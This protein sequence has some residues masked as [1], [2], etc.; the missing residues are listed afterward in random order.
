MLS[1]LRFVIGAVMATV[2][3]GVTLFGF[4]AAMHISHQSK[5]GPLEASRMLAYTPESRHRIF[6]PPARRFDNPFANIPVAANPVLLQQSTVAIPVLPA[7][8]PAEPAEPQVLPTQTAAAAQSAAESP[9]EPA[10]SDADTVD[11]R[12]VV[13]PPLPPDG[14]VPAEAAEAAPAAESPEPSE[15]SAPAIETQPA[16]P[17]AETAIEPAAD[18]PHV[19]SIPPTTDVTE[20]R[21]ET[22]ASQTPQ[23]NA[24]PHANE[25][26]QG[27]A[28]P[29]AN[30][31][32]SAGE[33]DAEEP[34]PAK[35]KRAVRKAAK[36]APARRAV[37]QP[38][39]NNPFAA[40]G[41]QLGTT[42]TANR[43]AKGFWPTLD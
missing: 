16:A 29:Q 27:N 40:T 8:Q 25:G 41:Y 1:D 43:P 18:V 32:P 42:S 9:L 26:P 13:D 5:V 17:V 20:T 12:A 39:Y 10:V 3:L 38:Q 19:G 6:D 34:A 14:D 35:R 22:P 28:P 24:A 37:L 21:D 4:A 36:K 2:L 33:A 30:A 31:A 7:Q 23:A 11:E 15:V